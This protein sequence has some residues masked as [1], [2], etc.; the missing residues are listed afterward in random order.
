MRRVIDLTGQKFGRLTV[1]CRSADHIKPC[2]TK[3]ITWLCRCECGNS[4]VVTR[5][6]LRQGKTKSC[7]CIGKDI[8]RTGRGRM[9]HGETHTKLYRVWSQ[10]IQRCTNPNQDKY[11]IYGGRGITVCKE[12]ICSYV[13]FRDWALVSGYEEGLTIDRIDVDGNYEPSNCRWATRSE[14]EANKRK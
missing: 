5:N 6:N 11:P 10:M 3:S 14:Q 13:A 9:T 2:G 1:V 8:N 4:V 7:G 12:W